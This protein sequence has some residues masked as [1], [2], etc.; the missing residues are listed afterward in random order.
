V[1]ANIEG[2]LNYLG[3][4]NV[5][6]ADS[7][8]THFKG[9]V[10]NGVPCSTVVNIR[11]NNCT[12][13]MKCLNAVLRHSDVHS[14]EC[15]LTLDT[16]DILIRGFLGLNDSRFWSFSYK[17][18]NRTGLF[19]IHC[20][21]RFTWKTIRWTGILIWYS[22]SLHTNRACPIENSAC[23]SLTRLMVLITRSFC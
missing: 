3:R 13:T 18:T 1:E 11:I 22:D 7:S 5:F 16:Q 15:R 9:N 6:G 21:V 17:K 12:G 20:K 14:V 4:Q 2:T 10:I 19:L 8:I 23:F